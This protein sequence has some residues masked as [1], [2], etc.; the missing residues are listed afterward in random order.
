MDYKI[1]LVFWLLLFRDLLF[2]LNFAK[3]EKNVE[4]IFANFVQ[5][6]QIFSKFMKVFIRLSE[7]VKK[8]LLNFFEINYLIH[9]YTFNIIRIDS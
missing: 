1:K 6:I 3:L 2:R 4:K 5:F 9:H 7:I 8:K